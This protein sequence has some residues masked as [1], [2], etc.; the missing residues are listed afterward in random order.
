[1]NTAMTSS[2]HIVLHDVTLV[3]PPVELHVFRTLLQATEPSITIDDRPRGS[4][5]L[6][7]KL[8]LIKVSAVARRRQLMCRSVLA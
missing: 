5:A 7:Q 8:Q 1:M 6:W 2:P 3:V 4:F